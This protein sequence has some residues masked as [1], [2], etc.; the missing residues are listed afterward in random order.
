MHAFDKNNLFEKILTLQIIKIV[1]C[2]YNNQWKYFHVKFSMFKLLE[3]YKD[4]FTK[5]YKAMLEEL[6]EHIN[7]S[8]DRKYDVY[9]GTAGL[10]ISLTVCWPIFIS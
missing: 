9:S 6:E 7:A 8:D 2:I 5:T 4:K 3:P 1:N 10:S